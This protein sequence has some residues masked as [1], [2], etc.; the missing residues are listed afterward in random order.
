LTVVSTFSLP[1]DSEKVIAA[2][3]S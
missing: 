1:T 2:K 3:P